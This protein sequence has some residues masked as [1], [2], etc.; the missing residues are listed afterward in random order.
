M[1]DRHARI[2]HIRETKKLATSRKYVLDSDS[3]MATLTV[4]PTSRRILH[5]KDKGA[6]SMRI[7]YLLSIAFCV[8]L[9][10][11][12]A[13]AQ[14]TTGMVIVSEDS[15][16]VPRVSLFVYGYANEPL[17]FF[18]LSPVTLTRNGVDVSSWL[19]SW[20][21]PFWNPSAANGTIRIWR[22]EISGLASGANTFVATI[23][24]A[25]DPM[26]CAADTTIVTYAGSTATPAQA[27]PVAMLGQSS[28]VRLLDACAA[29][30]SRTL[31]YSVP[32][33]VTNN[34]TGELALY[35]S[36][37]LAR[38]VGVV[39]VDVSVRSTAAPSRLSLRLRRNG[40]FV[41]LSNGAT[42]AFVHGDTGRVRLAALFPAD[43]LP[44]GAYE[45]DV[46][47]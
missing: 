32:T 24:K 10:S 40:A 20:T 29:C 5:R 11:A 43:T 34:Q 12:R 17:D 33:A 37:E 15:T 3:R 26:D 1:E 27:Q 44:S 36:S 25:T 38:P 6:P 30:A 42:E 39:E 13:F 41:T 23:C 4:T 35:Y 16:T 45:F 21:T 22:G 19:S 28:T 46:I 47:V 2:P 14:T 9:F 18:S 7:G 8:S 31:L